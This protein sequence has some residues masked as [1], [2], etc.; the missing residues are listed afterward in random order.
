MSSKIGNSNNSD[1]HSRLQ[2]RSAAT[3]VTVKPVRLVQNFTSL[4]LVVIFLATLILSMVLTQNARTVLM[5]KNQDY[6]ALIA[7]NLN[8]QVF[9]QYVYP[10]VKQFGRINLYNEAE[11]GLLDSVVRHTLHGFNVDVVNIYN[12]ENQVL[13]SF[14]PDLIGKK[15]T[16]GREYNMALKDVSSSKLMQTGSGWG[17]W[18]GRPESTIL[19]TYSPF[20][21][22]H[23]ETEEMIKIYGV[24]EIGI[25]LS[26][27]YRTIFNFQLMVVGVSATVMLLLF[28]VLRFYVGRGEDFLL[29]RA[30]ER[31]K[32]E[33]Q[34]SRAERLASLG[35]MAAG[36]SH[37]IRNPLGI[38]RSSA[39][40]L[41]KRYDGPNRQLLEVIIEESTR[42]ND[43]ITDFLNFARPTEPR[44][45]E[46]SVAGVLGKNLAF[47]AP[48]LNQDGYHV[49]QEA[50]S[51]L[52]MV[53]ADPNLLYQS[54]LNILINAMQAM[55]AGG[56]VY[57]K[58]RIQGEKLSVSFTDEGKGV[59]DEAMKK[60]WNPFF[61]TKERGTGLGLC[62][63]RNII[64]AHGGS[65][66]IE[67]SEDKGACVRVELPI[68]T[69]DGNDSDS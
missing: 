22:R 61:T 67:N 30:E 69:R 8:H 63:V 6:A 31:L 18:L 24:F 42:L 15:V 52:P 2:G 41:G 27:D 35:E 49:E 60:I 32:L 11:F 55:P 16:L 5:Q 68:G 1:Q 43:I 40:L 26:N 19:K 34:L 59:T 56:T 23:P 47:L 10:T 46:C 38:I 48:R 54:F 66:T 13:Y 36:V 44:F 58:T 25:D 28:L 9:W 21:I 14:D 39:E 65:V 3:R 7:N 37:E 50:P 4:S 33:E 17:I 64:E 12:E 62:V 29:Q 45:Q 53:W 51:D 57:V 20:C